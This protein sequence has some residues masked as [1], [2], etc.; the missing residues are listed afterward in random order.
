[1]LFSTVCI[2]YIIPVLYVFI[3][4][5]SP[6]CLTVRIIIPLFHKATHKV[7]NQMFIQIKVFSTSVASVLTS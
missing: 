2:Y 7:L 6:S 1:M 4:F 5:D 3:F